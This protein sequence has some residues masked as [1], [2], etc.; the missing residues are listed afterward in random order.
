[1]MQ[2]GGLRSTYA[3]TGKEYVTRWNPLAAALAGNPLTEQPQTGAPKPG[4]FGSGMASGAESGGRD[5]TDKSF[6]DSIEGSVT[7]QTTGAMGAGTPGLGSGWGGKAGAIGTGLG[8]ASGLGGLG[9]LGNAVGTAVDVNNA[10]N[11]LGVSRANNPSMSAPNL[12]FGAWASG[13]LNNSTFGAF[14]TPVG[15]S[16]VESAINGVSMPG[17]PNQAPEPDALA[18]AQAGGYGYS[19]NGGGSG[20]DGGAGGYGA[21]G[22]DGPGGGYGGGGN[23]GNA[24]ANGGYVTKDRL[25]GPDP[26]GPDDGYGQLDHGEFVIKASDVKRLGGPDETRK[27]LAKLLAGK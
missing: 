10:N 8:L 19:D 27:R 1:M 18:A 20:F 26:V 21:G 16:M 2:Y 5:D 3:P 24:W 9:V 15:D 22:N 25:I 17:V 14:G 6:K 23:G 12:G 13:M 4:E 7:G 11:A